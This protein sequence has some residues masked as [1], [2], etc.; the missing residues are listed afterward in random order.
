MIQIN[1]IVYQN[2]LFFS[3]KFIAKIK[4][5]PNII[6]FDLWAKNI[7]LGP[8]TQNFCQKI[9]LTQ[10]LTKFFFQPPRMQKRVKLG[11]WA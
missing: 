2:D 4:F 6:F 3:Q 1:D 11:T 8:K 10:I 5:G 9:F 7:F